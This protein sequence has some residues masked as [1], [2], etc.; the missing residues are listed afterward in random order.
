M[1]ER[2]DP[3]AAAVRRV[4][5]VMVDGEVTKNPPRNGEGD[6][7]KH[8]GGVTRSAPDPSV[9]A[10]ALPPPRAGEDFR[11]SAFRTLGA[12]HQQVARARKLR[13]EMSLPEVLLWK[14][15][16]T[17][18]GGH[19]FRKQFPFESITADFA[20]LASRLIIE[21]DGENHSF[22]DR[23]QRDAARDRMLEQAGFSVLRVPAR[24]VLKN[25]DGV[26]RM[27]VGTCAERGPRRHSAARS[28][29]PPRSGE[30]F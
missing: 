13:K 8:G 29:P 28:G 4:Q 7:A 27:I 24:E 20:C 10:D 6:H 25:M 18:P 14:R 16:Q 17:R 30:D 26:V 12:S 23:S 2:A 22:G 3:R 21:V 11:R 1:P 5:D 9:S 19:R 15:L